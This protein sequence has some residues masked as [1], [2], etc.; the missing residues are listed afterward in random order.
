M[1]KPQKTRRREEQRKATTTE[2][3]RN[4]ERGEKTKKGFSNRFFFSFSSFFVSLFPNFGKRSQSSLFS[5]FAGLRFVC[6]LSLKNLSIIGAMSGSDP[7][8]N[9]QTHTL[10]SNLNIFTNSSFRS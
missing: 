9:P 8:P 3:E 1:K 6:A 7:A 5:L 2:E 4:R 10:S